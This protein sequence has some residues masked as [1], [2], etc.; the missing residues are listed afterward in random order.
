[1]CNANMLS[2]IVHGTRR[3]QH[4]EGINCK[5]DFFFSTNICFLLER[6]TLYIFSKTSSGFSVDELSAQVTVFSQTGYKSDT[7]RGNK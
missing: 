2:P 5:S 1:M 4:K 7:L 3:Y 6:I